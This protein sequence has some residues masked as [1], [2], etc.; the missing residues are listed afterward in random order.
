MSDV[1]KQIIADKV[2][3]VAA[4]KADPDSRSFA[5]KAADMPPARG[6]A[7]ALRK[8]SAQ[9]YGLIAE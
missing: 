4:L 2:I 5:A 6:F 7:N 1:L 8:S 9:G 3:E